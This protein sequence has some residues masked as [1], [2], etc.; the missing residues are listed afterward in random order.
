MG[1]TNNMAHGKVV[2]GEIPQILDD[3]FLERR[4]RT[5][6]RLHVWVPKAFDKLAVGDF[7]EVSWDNSQP[8]LGAFFNRNKRDGKLLTY[9]ILN[10]GTILFKREK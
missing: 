5:L 4:H 10:K 3:K 1:V 8:A 6:N 7:F 2:K 9:K